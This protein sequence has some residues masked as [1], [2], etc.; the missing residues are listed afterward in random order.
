MRFPVA[1]FA[2][3]LLLSPR[4][5]APAERPLARVG[6]DRIDAQELKDDFVRRHGGH[7]RFLGGESEIRAFLDQVIDRRLLL[8]EAYRLGIDQQPDLRQAVEAFAE[9]T[10]VEKLVT[11][12]TEA[13]ARPTEAQIQLAWKTQTTT[14][15]QVWQLVLPTREAAEQAARELAGGADF[16]KLARERSIGRSRAMGG[17]IPSVGWGHASPE[18]EAAVFA[19]AAGETSKPFRSPDGWE[20]VRMEKKKPVDPPDYAQARNKIEGILKQR[21]LEERRRAF[22][23]ALWVK[24]HAAANATVPLVPAKLAD[25]LASA[26]KTV[27]VSWNS[28]TL[29]LDTFAQGLDLRAK[30]SLTDEQA[31]A[32]MDRL[33]RET[34]NDALVRR[35]VV[36]RKTAEQPELARAIKNLRENLMESILYAD[37]LLRGVELTDAEVRAAYDAHRAELALPE[38]RR[39]AH[40]VTAT[41][42]ESA[43]LRERLV[44]GEDFAALV[45]EKSTDVQTR[46]SGGDLGWITKKDTPA[47]FEPVLALKTGEISAP[48]QSKFGWHLLKVVAIEPPRQQSFEEVR[49]ALRQQLLDSK[50]TERRKEWIAKLRAATPIEID[51]KAI[52]AL[53]RKSEAELPA[54]PPS[55]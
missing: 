48:L 29:T 11:D 20:I 40:L 33:V 50:K 53:A 13:K 54:A 30:S 38:R 37:Y 35:E 34:V 24:Y 36:A 51:A 23:E 1:A 28:G 14:I 2:L 47:G 41:Q 8:Q 45:K 19:L 3:S 16:G 4:P 31:V 39:V 52:A 46:S 12:E 43:A 27:L 22:S 25:L 44:H 42:E 9:K 49:D 21:M 5:A 18:W 15:Y 26:P 10:A 6:D 17:M 32:E 55:H 7:A